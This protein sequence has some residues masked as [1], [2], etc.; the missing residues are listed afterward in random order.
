MILNV[1]NID[2]QLTR[3]RHSDY[4][5]MWCRLVWHTKMNKSCISTC[6][7]MMDMRLVLQQKR[8]GDS[9]DMFV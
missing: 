5:V 2:I 6:R 7:N 9:P 8:C 1:E 3:I 4:D